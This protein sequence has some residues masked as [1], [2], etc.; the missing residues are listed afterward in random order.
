MT[1]GTIRYGTSSWSEKAWGGVFYPE[2]LPAGE[3]L[4]YYATRFDTVEADV[5]YYRVPDERMVRGWERKTPAGFVL[6]AK[7]PRSVVHAGEGAQ[8]DGGKVLVR[9]HVQR[10]VERFLDAMRPLGPR[11]GPLVLQFPYFNR[12]AFDRPEAF[13]ERLEPFLEGLPPDFRYGVELRN[14]TWVDEPLLEVLRRRRVALV[15]V[16]LAYLPHPAELLERCD[17]FSADFA[18]ARLIGDRKKIDALTDSLD[19]VVL[20]QG[21]RLERWAELLRAAAGKVPETYVYANNHY[22]GYAPDTIEDLRGRVERA[23]A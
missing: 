16:D 17:P 20:D 7:F 12:R 18:Y 15:L 4:A 13:L 3:Q 6:S 19:R 23:R 10:D 14:K 11:C 21:A 1:A 8:P 5:T 9:E 2:G 22:A